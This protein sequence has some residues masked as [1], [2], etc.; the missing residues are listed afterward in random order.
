MNGSI[1]IRRPSR[2]APRAP[3]SGV[4]ALLALAFAPSAAARAADYEQPNPLCSAAY[5][6]A[7]QLAGPDFKVAPEATTDGFT[8]TYTVASRF[9]TFTAHGRVQVAL[10]ARE[11][12]ALAQLEEV[13]K[14]DVFLDAVKSSATAPLQLV[15]AVATKPVETLQGIPAGVGRWVKKTRF[16]VQEGY[17]DAKDLKAETAKKDEAEA[18]GE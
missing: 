14:S 8:N 4:L 7:E 12:Q 17:Q 3:G 15:Q 18:G 16:Q 1:S 10:R 13:S 11:I 6:T 9:G 5:L 2:V